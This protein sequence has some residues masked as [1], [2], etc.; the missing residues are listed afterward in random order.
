M[1]ISNVNFTFF[2]HKYGIVMHLFYHDLSVTYYSVWGC[3]CQ[4]YISFHVLFTF[5]VITNVFRIQKCFVCVWGGG[6]A[7][8]FNQYLKFYMRVDT[9]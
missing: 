8:V 2:G 1:L 3:F 7:G 5:H 9:P 4:K 6:G